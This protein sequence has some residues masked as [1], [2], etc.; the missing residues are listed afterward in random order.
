MGDSESRN[1]ENE[2]NDVRNTI[3]SSPLNEMVGCQR[4]S[5]LTLFVGSQCRKNGSNGN[6]NGLQA[7]LTVLAAGYMNEEVTE[8]FS[9]EMR[10][11]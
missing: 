1:K 5:R 2:R 11:T 9:I 8:H 4:G 7:E 6:E 10:P 3:G